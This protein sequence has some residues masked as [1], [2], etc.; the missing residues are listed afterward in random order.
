MYIN[1]RKIEF[2]LQKNENLSLKKA[3]ETKNIAM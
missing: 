2:F 3:S 1:F